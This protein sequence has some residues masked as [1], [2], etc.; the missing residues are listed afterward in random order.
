MKVLY[1]NVF[2]VP[3]LIEKKIW[4]VD[5]YLSKQFNENLFKSYRKYGMDTQ[6]FVY[7]RTDTIPHYINIKKNI[8]PIPSA[9][10]FNKSFEEVVEERAKELLSYN[11]PISVVWSGGI[12]STLALFA[13][14][15]FANDPEQISVYGT[16]S[17]ILESGNMFDNY[18]IPSGVKYNITTSKRK[19]FEDDGL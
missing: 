3:N 8:A 16:Y 12:D 19:E 18:I 10:G 11:K 7:D 13:L 1:Y 14:I 17:S 9:D 15:K 2:L 6:N 4:S 5:K